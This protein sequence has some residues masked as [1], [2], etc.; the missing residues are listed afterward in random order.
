[1]TK[2]GAV[3][4]QVESRARTRAFYCRV[5]QGRSHKLALVCCQLGWPS[6]Q[7]QS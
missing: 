3:Q 1:M 4:Q 5:A 7:Q 2:H 6:K